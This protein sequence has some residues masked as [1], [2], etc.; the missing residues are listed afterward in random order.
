MNIVG[1]SVVA[2]DARHVPGF[3]MVG[4]DVTGRAVFRN[5][6]E[7]LEG[8][9]ANDRPLEQVSGV[10]LVYLKSRPRDRDCRFSPKLKDDRKKFARVADHAG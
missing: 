4:G 3:D 2:H 7:V 9:T 1:D 8:C 6:A 5:G 10:D